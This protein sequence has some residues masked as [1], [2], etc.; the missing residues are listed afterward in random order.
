MPPREVLRL[1]D[2]SSHEFIR[3][4][5]SVGWHAECFSLSLFPN[6]AHTHIRAVIDQTPQPNTAS[7]SPASPTRTSEER[8][9]TTPEERATKGRTA[10]GGRRRQEAKVVDTLQPKEQPDRAKPAPRDSV[11]L[12]DVYHTSD[13]C[14]EDVVL[15]NAD[16]VEFHR[17]VHTAAGGACGWNPIAS[18]TF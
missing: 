4:G 16:A 13:S 2:V 11:P 1:D 9:T 3:I 6:N 12:V 14:I 17:G 15:H 8:S 5:S 7:T 18:G 10:T